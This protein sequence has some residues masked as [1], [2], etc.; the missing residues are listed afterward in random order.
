MKMKM[1]MKMKYTEQAVETLDDAGSVIAN[2]NIEIEQL[3]QRV[4][5]LEA[6]RETTKAYYESVFADGASRIKSLT[7]E[8]DAALKKAEL[9]M[10]YKRMTFNAELQEEITTLKSALV[11]A[12]HQMEWATQH[13]EI[14]RDS[15]FESIATIKAVLGEEK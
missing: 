11:E 6:E 3:R 7:A 10:K 1:K 15:W 5:E 8:R 2:K 12:K 13:I 14:H 4:A 9:P